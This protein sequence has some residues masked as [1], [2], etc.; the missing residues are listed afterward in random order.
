MTTPYPRIPYGE[1]SFPRIRRKGWL[2]VDKTRF[3]R[4]L[5]DEPYAFFIRPRRFGKSC[6]LSLLE[7]YYGRHW[8]GEFETLFGG[9]DIARAPTAERHRYVV[10][11]FNFS[12]FD[13][14]LETLE[15]RF[16]FY[17]H[18]EI[19]RALERNADLFPEETT[20]RILSAP[21]VDGKLYQ[22]FQYA[23][24]RGIPLCVLIDEYDN[25]A[26]TV[27]AHRGRE[28]YESLTH[29]GGFYRNFFATLKGR[30]RGDGRPGAAVHHR[31]IA[32]HDGR[33]D[34]RLQHRRQP[35]PRAR[36]S[37]RC[38]GSRSRRSAACSRPTATTARSTR[39]WTRPL[40]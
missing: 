7:G 13:D 17:C 35:Q 38:S 20:R 2:Y 22:L 10:V 40:R 34:Q 16:G 3:V 14:T 33:R 15:E 5:E 11:R 32:H 37:T 36:S 21:A 19:R 25:F 23:G 24:D 26:N 6:W 4:P 30:R 18:T 9:T 1:A 39:T 29:G 28:S 12:A 8:A 31:R 27:L